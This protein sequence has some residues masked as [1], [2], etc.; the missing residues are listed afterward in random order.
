MRLYEKHRPKTLEDIV[1]QPA[2]T[3]LKQFACEPYP[4]IILLEGPPGTGKTAAAMILAEQLGD[5]GWFGGSVY[6]ERGA[7]F[8]TELAEFYFGREET[9]FRYK[10]SDGKY[11]VLVIEELERLPP[12]VEADLKQAMEDAQR[13]YRAIVIATSNDTG[14]LSAA[15]LQRFQRFHFG[16][17][18][19][20]AD[21]F[22]DTL[23]M[24]WFGE[25]GNLDLPDDWREL[26]WDGNQFS[27]R[28]ALNALE[29][30][31]AV[32]RSRRQEGVLA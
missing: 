13:D 6:Q 15:F 11:H 3:A 25:T 4:H 28:H 10:V 21:A 23:P 12:N 8:K 2:I 32:Q 17:G 19:E 5:T 1:G 27:G 24:L 30:H 20:F 22:N 26:G 7:K 18:R 29:Q 31:I 16:G 14:K 9:P